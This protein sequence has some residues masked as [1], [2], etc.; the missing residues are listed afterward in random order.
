MKVLGLMIALGAL[1][2]STG[3]LATT[4]GEERV[5]ECVDDYSVAESQ[6]PEVT[7][8][9]CSCMDQKMG[10]GE[11]KSV[12]EWEVLNAPDAASCEKESGWEQ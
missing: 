11:T 8:K 2:T 5:N 9:Y 1:V 3:V 10:A 12:L 6:S 4:A 7:K